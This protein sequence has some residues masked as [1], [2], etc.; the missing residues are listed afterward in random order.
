MASKDCNSALIDVDYNGEEVNVA[1][2]EVDSRHATKTTTLTTGSYKQL[3]SG[4]PP[5]RQR[6]LTST[7]SEHYEFL[8]LDVDGNLFVN[9]KKCS[10]M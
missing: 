5:K 1:E 8:E 3:T 4:K 10:Q 2:V 6:K 9:A 7:V